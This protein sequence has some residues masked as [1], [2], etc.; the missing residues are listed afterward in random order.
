ML[1]LL[2]TLLGLAGGL[3]TFVVN[4]ILM[5]LSGLWERVFLQHW[6][7]SEGKELLRGVV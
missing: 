2:P 6:L 4:W 1:L 3:R 7:C 5:L